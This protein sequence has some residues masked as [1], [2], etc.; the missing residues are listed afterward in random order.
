MPNSVLTQ[1]QLAEERES[2]KQ[3]IQGLQDLRQEYISKGKLNAAAELEADIVK[4]QA[5]EQQL[6]DKIDNYTTFSAERTKQDAEIQSTQNFEAKK[7][8]ANYPIQQQ[9]K[10]TETT[11]GGNATTTAGPDL[12]LTAQQADSAKLA[13]QR[14]RSEEH[15]SELSH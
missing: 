9:T 2:L 14:A 4:K 11:T 6:K 1:A 5:S 7:D 3:D 8:P 12:T 13:G 10:V 15:T